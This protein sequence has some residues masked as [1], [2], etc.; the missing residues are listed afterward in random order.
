MKRTNSVKKLLCI[1]TALAPL[2]ISSI[3]TAG[4]G[5]FDSANGEFDFC[6]SVRF[7]ATNTQLQQIRDGF[8]AGSQILSD[9]TDGQHQ[10]WNGSTG[11]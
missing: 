4:T 1:T 2:F 5:R 10:F 3:A 11:E 9:A 8:S 6:V 7:N